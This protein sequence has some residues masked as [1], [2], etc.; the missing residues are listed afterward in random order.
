MTT[1]ALPVGLRM[2][3]AFRRAFVYIA[4]I[5]GAFL[6]IFPF[7]WMVL[8]SF[9]NYAE[10]TASPPQFIPIMWAQRTSIIAKMITS[11][12]LLFAGLLLWTILGVVIAWR[13]HKG[14]W[15]AL[16]AIAHLAVGIAAWNLGLFGR[17]LTWNALWAEA[18][19]A[20][21]YE[22]TPFWDN[23]VKAW[24]IAP[25]GRYFINSAIMSTVTPLLIICTAA[26]AAYAFA[27]MRFPGKDIVFCTL[28]GDHDDS[29]RGHLDPQLCHHLQTQMDRY[30]SGADPALDRERGH[31]LFPAP[32]LQEHP[33]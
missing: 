21:G 2:T 32:V 25:F 31:Y 19:K 12:P 30:L 8:T 1:K 20:L 16:Y 13:L 5:F 28:F 18:L 9:K 22:L 29:G 10:A 4:L 14:W 23:Y 6:A 7:V 15:G 24:E 27:R 3:Y 33:R 17:A 11:Q 26:P